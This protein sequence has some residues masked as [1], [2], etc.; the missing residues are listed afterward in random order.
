MQ[1]LGMKHVMA[2]FVPQLLLPEWKEHCVAVAN[3][4]IQTA[5]NEPDFLMKVITGDESGIYGSDPE[6]KA[7]TTKEGVA[8]SRPYFE[9]W[10]RH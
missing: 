10:K 5:T 4:L 2:N 7:P 1:G 3:D 9:Q 6:V 8:R